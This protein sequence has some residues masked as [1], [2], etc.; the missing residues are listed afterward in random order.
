MEGS[1][2]RLEFAG[3]RPGGIKKLKCSKGDIYRS[4]RIEIK[5]RRKNT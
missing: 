4:R 2:W 3:E 1:F 5:F